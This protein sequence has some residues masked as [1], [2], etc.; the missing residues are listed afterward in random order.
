MN[1]S[2]STVQS[3]TH[4]NE[5]ALKGF[6]HMTANRFMMASIKSVMKSTPPIPPIGATVSVLDSRCAVLMDAIKSSPNFTKEGETN[7]HFIFTWVASDAELEQMER[8]HELADPSVKCT[9][10]SVFARPEAE[11]SQRNLYAANESAL[12]TEVFEDEERWTSLVAADTAACGV[13]MLSMI[14]AI[15]A[16]SEER[17]K[18][19]E[20]YASQVI[21]PI[22]PPSAKDS[23]AIR[24]SMERI[25]MKPVT[26]HSFADTMKEVERLNKGTDQCLCS[27]FK[28]STPNGT[29]AVVS[30][31]QTTPYVNFELLASRELGMDRGNEAVAVV[32]ITQDEAAKY[33]EAG[34][35]M[36]M[37]KAV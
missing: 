17:E 33:V 31:C 37:L 2:S 24:E 20:N 21:E 35:K 30:A 9:A 26:A 7:R 11:R 14:A 4:S 18:M 16:V 23:E 19:E 25:G 36:Y 6:A 10:I 29:E 28:V 5:E 34:K 32:R 12:L 1:A 3:I 8:K 27:L 13:S 22:T 15:S